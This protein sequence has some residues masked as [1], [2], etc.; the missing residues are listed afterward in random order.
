[1]I[2]ISFI[3]FSSVLTDLLTIY[4]KIHYV[5]LLTKLKLTE[6]LHNAYHGQTH[7]LL[8]TVPNILMY[9]DV[10][11]RARVFSGR[12]SNHIESYFI[13]VGNIQAI[14]YLGM[15]YSSGT[16]IVRSCRTATEVQHH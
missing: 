11:L 7:D 6:Q 14:Y 8:H 12:A 2:C 13:P 9:S 1:M 15:M 3:R 5:C 10:R 4:N 16:G